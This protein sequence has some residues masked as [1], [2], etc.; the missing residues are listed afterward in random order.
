MRED[1]AGISDPDACYE[2]VEDDELE[3]VEMWGENE[4]L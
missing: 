4:V 3:L 1:A 2:G